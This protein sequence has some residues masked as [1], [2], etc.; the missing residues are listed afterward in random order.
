MLGARGEEA[1]KQ[2]N[3][4]LASF[5]FPMSSFLGGSDCH[6]P[7]RVSVPTNFIESGA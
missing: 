2:V 1:E 5:E 6:L 3:L 4:I 7:S